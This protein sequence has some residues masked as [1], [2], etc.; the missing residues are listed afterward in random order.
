[1]SGSKPQKKPEGMWKYPNL[2]KNL[3]DVG[4]QRISHYIGV[5]RQYI[6]WPQYQYRYLRNM[7]IAQC[8]MHIAQIFVQYGFR[9]YI[10]LI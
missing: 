2:E 10:L 3:W 7:H 1:M 4:L 6:C 9:V 5:Q 8:N